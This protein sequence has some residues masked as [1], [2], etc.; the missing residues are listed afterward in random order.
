MT[1]SA[2]LVQISTDESLREAMP[3]A[4]WATSALFGIA[5]ALHVV[6]QAANPAK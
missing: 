2:R 3:I 1:F 6:D 4:R 5:Y